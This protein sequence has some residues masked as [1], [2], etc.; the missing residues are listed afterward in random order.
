VHCD[1][2]RPSPNTVW[3]LRFLPPAPPAPAAAAVATPPAAGPTSAAAVIA[4]PTPA[5]LGPAAPTAAARLSSEGC[6]PAIPV[7]GAATEAPLDA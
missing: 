1:F 3:A 6:A 5:E 7:A 2:F 4:V